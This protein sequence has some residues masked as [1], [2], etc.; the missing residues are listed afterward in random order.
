[1]TDKEKTNLLQEIATVIYGESVELS[2]CVNDLDDL[3][4]SYKDKRERVINVPFG[5]LLGKTV[6]EIKGA[7]ENNDLI[8]FKCS[9]GSVYVMYHEQDCCESV[10]IED[11]CGNITNLIGSPITRAEECIQ[12]NEDERH[13]DES[14]TWTFYNLATLNG[15]VTLRWYGSS[16]GYYSESVDFVKI[17]NTGVARKTNFDLVKEMSPV[18]LLIWALDVVPYITKQHTNSREGLYQWL[19]SEVTE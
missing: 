1:M 14:H 8:M 11:I 16:N 19:I 13:A 2:E 4:Y 12:I 5:E 15:Y 10:D 7:E 3:F 9:D 6:V 17:K 18:E